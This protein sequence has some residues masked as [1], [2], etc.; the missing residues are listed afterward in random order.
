MSGAVQ[1]LMFGEG[2]AVAER[3]EYALEG[4]CESSQN[5]ASILTQFG[6]DVRMDA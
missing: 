1:V 5:R 6:I 3:C 2:N 4:Q